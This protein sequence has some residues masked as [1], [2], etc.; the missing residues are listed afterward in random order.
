MKTVVHPESGL[1]KATLTDEELVEMPW[2]FCRIHAFAVT[3]YEGPPWDDMTPEGYREHDDLDPTA[4]SDLLLH[5]DLDYIVRRVEFGP[6]R[7]V[8]YWVAPATLIF[9]NVWDIVG[10]LRSVCLPLELKSLRQ[11]EATGRAQDHCWHLEGRD[12][13]LR[14]QASR[15]TLYVRRPPRYGDRVLRMAERGGISFD[16]HPFA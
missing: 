12:M 16:P 8:R 5:L 7:D 15:Y 4:P 9:D 6:L 2:D 1:W 10:S 14:F 13:D 3:A 11:E